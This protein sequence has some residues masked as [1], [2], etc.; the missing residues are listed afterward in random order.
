MLGAASI[1]A[2]LTTGK[3]VFC[4]VLSILAWQHSQF[5]AWV[6]GPILGHMIFGK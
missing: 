4:H 6:N 5:L 3:V 1:V 2:T